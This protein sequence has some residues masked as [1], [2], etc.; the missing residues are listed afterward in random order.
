M[1]GV[2]VPRVS[3]SGVVRAPESTTELVSASL[4]VDRAA[5][6]L[7]SAVAAVLRR[8]D[9]SLEQWRVLEELHRLGGLPMSAIAGS[10]MVPGPTCTRLVDKLASE[11]L[12][13]RSSDGGDRRRVLVRISDRGRRLHERLAPLVADAEARAMSALLPDEERCLRLLL[14]RIAAQG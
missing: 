1:K 13:Y 6:R 14:T 9:V 5:H 4:I 2:P 12:V 11:A 8:E 3:G 10:I 7:S